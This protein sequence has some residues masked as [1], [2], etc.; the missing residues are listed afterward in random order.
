M[1]TNLLILGAG[2]SANAG[3]PLAS[4]FTANLLKTAGLNADGPSRPQVKFLRRF[5]DRTF[6]EG[7]PRKPAEWPELEDILTI[8]D[9]SA[10]TGHHLG[11]HYS[12]SDLRVVRRAILVRMTRMLEQ[13]YRAAKK[14]AGPAWQAL[15]QFFEKLDLDDVTVLS[16]NWDMVFE[17]G[18]MRTQGVKQF[19]YGCGAQPAQFRK[20]RLIRARPG[21]TQTLRLL[22]P[23]GSVNWLYCDACREIFWVPPDQIER[24]AK[25][26]FR[27]KDWRVLETDGLLTSLP[28]TIDPACP[29]CRGKALG[30]RFATFSY[31][32]A[33]DFAMHAASWR[34]AEQDLKRTADWVFMGY[35]MP[36]ADFEFK[37]MLKRVQLSEPHRP[38]I[39]LITGGKGAPD[40]I[41]RFE[42]FFGKVAGERHY[43]DNG[44]DAP[45]LAHLRRRGVLRR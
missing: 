21:G 3:L 2:F 28:E 9:M 15:E 7:Y 31:R 43:F 32:K 19:D 6:G 44:L 20:D 42:K 17:R 45:A 27:E 29:H 4:E 1:A 16:M 14:T 30:T 5:V 41:E 24:V 13:R 35:S 36:P 10:N 26:L 12:A 39:T 37:Q 40:T 34:S 38:I 11:P 8:I 33:L 25:A 22:K 18:V 23:H